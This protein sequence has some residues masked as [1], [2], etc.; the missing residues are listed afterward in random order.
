QRGK[1]L[2]T[3]ILKS[4]FSTIS[5]NSGNYDYSLSSGPAEW[6]PGATGEV[7]VAVK[8]K[9]TNHTQELTTK[10]TVVDTKAPTAEFE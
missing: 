7:T 6:A 8:N 9:T 1:E 5:E 3:S 10:Y 4:W 2:S